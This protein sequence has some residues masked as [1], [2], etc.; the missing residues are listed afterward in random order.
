MPESGGRECQ[1]A[2]LSAI[3][4]GKTWP[5]MKSADERVD[6][7]VLGGGCAGLSLASRLANAANAPRVAV[8]E[9]RSSYQED[10][11]WCG[12]RLE[13]HFF[14]DCVVREWD[15]W[16]VLSPDGRSV[17]RS[18]RYPY[19]MVSAGH[20]YD[21]A[22]LL[23]E[24]S[25][26][27][28]LLQSARVSEVKSVEGES[29][30]HLS[31]GRQ[32]R[33]PWVIDTRPRTGV[34]AWPWIW[35]HFVGYVV[36]FDSA[37]DGALGTV[38]TLM[39]FQAEEG[40]V[41]QFVYVLPVSET[42]FLVE[43]TRLSADPG[44]AEGQMAAIEYRLQRWLE[45]HGGMDWKRLRR[46]SGSLPMAVPTPEANVPGIV[47]AGMRG[48]SMRASSGY[49]FH[50]IQRWADECTLS[51]L[52]TGRPVAPVRKRFLEALDASFLSVLQ[53]EPGAA[54]KLFAALFAHCPADPL[55]RFMAGRPHPCDYWPVVASLPWRRFVPAL[56][57]AISEWC[58]A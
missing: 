54:W 39:D 30:V 38:P 19:E 29:L 41:A 31:D 21:K 49:A 40:H 6:L 51:L 47:Q 2:F 46:E 37:R 12:W 13:S 56:P 3:D 22:L 27:V 7:I 52:Q 34:L 42:Q 48:G 14:S 9:A 36:E 33:A 35:Q 24:R 15:G 58:R 11:T 20:F 53:K 44:A 1:K 57:A 4:L 18:G 55:V 23:I 26:Q 45:Q 17:Q 32:L 8:V 16:Q 10:R 50:S 5:N 25:S 43:W 28:E